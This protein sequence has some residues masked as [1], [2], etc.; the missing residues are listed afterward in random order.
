MSKKTPKYYAHNQSPLYGIKTNKRLAEVL[1]CDLGIMEKIIQGKRRYYKMFSEK[2]GAKE[3]T[4]EEPIKKLRV[5][6]DR[7]SY[8]LGKINPPD[9]LFCPVKGK[10]AVL[11]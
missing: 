5:L 2:Q 9:F 11:N 1:K 10:S 7:I 4:I 3:R 8:F 6:H